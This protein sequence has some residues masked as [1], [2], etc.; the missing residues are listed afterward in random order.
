MSD[1]HQP[2]TCASCAFIELTKKQNIALASA[3]D[4]LDQ[5]RIRERELVSRLKA[6]SE[7]AHVCAG[8]CKEA[9]A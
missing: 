5:L 6:Q 1:T 3:W 2:S 9:R 4:Q 8:R 7:T